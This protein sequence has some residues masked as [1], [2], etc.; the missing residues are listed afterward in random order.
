MQIWG[1]VHLMGTRILIQMKRMLWRVVS[2]SYKLVFSISFLILLSIKNWLCLTI[3]HPLC[4]SKGCMDVL[5]IEV[6]IRT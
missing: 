1:H 5:L 3:F 6:I 4:V 2:V